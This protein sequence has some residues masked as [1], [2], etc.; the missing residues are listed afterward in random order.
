VVLTDTP[1]NSRARKI[2]DAFSRILGRDVSEAEQLRRVR[3]APGVENNHSQRKLFAGSEAM[4]KIEVEEFEHEVLENYHS[5]EPPR[6]PH[7]LFGRLLEIRVSLAMAQSHSDTAA[8]LLP[9]Y[10]RCDLHW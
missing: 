6:H 9:L 4:E 3:P 2:L 5:D 10:Y 8:V 7:R 1:R